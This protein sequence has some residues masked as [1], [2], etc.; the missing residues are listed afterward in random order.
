MNILEYEN[1][2][3]KKD[4][5]TL[6]F[7]YNTYLC[8]IPLDF[9]LV[10][11]HWHDEMEIIN[12][13]DGE[14]NINIDLKT[15]TV[16]AGELAIIKPGELH[17]F[18]QSKDQ[19]CQFLSLIFS[20]RLLENTLG[21]STALR[22]LTP[23][24]ENEISCPSII[25]PDMEGYSQIMQDIDQSFDIYDHKEP[26]YELALKAKLFDFFYLLLKNCCCVDHAPDPVR[27]ATSRNIKIIIDYI[28]ENYAN[29]ISISELA[30]LLNFSEHY[31]MRYFKNNMGVTCIEF[32]NDYR[33]N[34]A[35][36]LL[37]EQDKSISEIAIEVG[38]SNI[39]Y[40]NRIFKKKFGVTPKDYR[41]QNRIH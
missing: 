10:P 5:T 25:T 11:P 32:I 6:D 30:N 21:D 1:Y 38:V 16:H 24:F 40:F 39:S 20:T 28:S 31:F 19:K 2:Q 9:E 29:T 12:V 18:S 26:F 23:L 17:S 13:F 37:T 3:E 33:L 7:P 27:K 22:Y 36:K 14:L 34:Q 35:V 41:F 8:S 15:Y 4:H